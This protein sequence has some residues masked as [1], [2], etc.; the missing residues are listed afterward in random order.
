MLRRMNPLEAADTTLFLTINQ[1][2]P[3]TEEL[4]ALMYALTTIMNRGDAWV[5]GLIVASLIDPRRG[6]RALREVL[7]SLWLTA[8]TVEVPIKRLFRRRRPFISIVRAI[9][10]GK[11]PGG[12]S[13]PSG[14]SAV[15]F[16][17][18]LLL[19]RHF[20]RMGPIFYLI[21]ALTGFSRIYLGAHYP[22]DVV[23]GAAIGSGLAVLFRRLIS[24]LLHSIRRW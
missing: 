16:G 9:V 15:A 13:F 19:T 21:A 22:G 20:P 18:A 23:T 7:P 17:G 11:K 5:L 3:R 8:V 6:R 12:Y 4:N 24:W 1:R 14:H 10:V 2:T